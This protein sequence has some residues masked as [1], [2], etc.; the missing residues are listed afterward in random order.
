MITTLKYHFLQK[1]R[2]ADTG[3][4]ASRKLKIQLLKSFSD[5]KHIHLI[6]IQKDVTTF[7]K[8]KKNK[9]FNSPLKKLL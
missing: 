8:R 9:F 7:L 2:A 3:K 5:E 4:T 6:Y 1:S